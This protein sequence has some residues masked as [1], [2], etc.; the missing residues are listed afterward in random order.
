MGFTQLF[1][2]HGEDGKHD[3]GVEAVP[4]ESKKKM[5]RNVSSDCKSLFCQLQHY[6]YC[7]RSDVTQL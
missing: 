3:C 5:K 2:A 4:N 6:I 7:M 1:D